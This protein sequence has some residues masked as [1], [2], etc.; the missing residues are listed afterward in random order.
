M[1]PFSSSKPFFFRPI[2]LSY[3]TRAHVK[4][5]PGCLWLET[6]AKG[7]LLKSKKIYAVLFSLTERKV[8]RSTIQI[9]K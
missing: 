9:K 8:S 4:S 3:V 1:E 2:S 6:G 5:I 7:K